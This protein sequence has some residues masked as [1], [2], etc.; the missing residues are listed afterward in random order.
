M[1]KLD[2]GR[3][4]SGGEKLVTGQKKDGFSGHI[5]KRVYKR[6]KVGVGRWGI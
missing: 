4:T 2:R 1:R 5:A 6:G 3:L